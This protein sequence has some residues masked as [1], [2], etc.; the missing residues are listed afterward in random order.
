MKNTE[1]TFN[2]KCIAMLDKIKTPGIEKPSLF[3]VPPQYGGVHCME[4]IDELAMAYYQ[5][6]GIRRSIEK[7]V[8]YNI[9]PAQCDDIQLLQQTIVNQPRKV[10]NHYNKFEGVCCYD[11]SNIKQSVDSL[12][13]HMMIDFVN[14]NTNNTMFIFVLSSNDKSVISLVFKALKMNIHHTRI[15]QIIMA[16]ESVETYSKYAF[17]IL[18]NAGVN[19]RNEAQKIIDGYIKT[20][21]EKKTFAGYDSISRFCRDLLNEINM[22]NKKSLTNADLIKI[23]DVLIDD[24]TV[25]F[26]KKIGF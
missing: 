1:H 3:I 17:E 10:A 14:Q 4:Y 22:N 12:A 23:K 18:K 7:C 16:Y 13:F 9:I 25:D 24:D 19:V 11:L 5:S 15:E 21:M 6:S 26:A 8:A 2:P 20:I